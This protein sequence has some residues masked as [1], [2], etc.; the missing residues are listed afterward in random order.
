MVVRLDS[1]WANGGTG[2]ITLAGI[3]APNPP[4][5]TDG[6]RGDRYEEYEFTAW[7]RT[8]SG[9]LRKLSTIIDRDENNDITI[10]A[11]QP[12]V[13]VGNIGPGK[14]TLKISPDK[15]YETYSDRDDRG[16]LIEP[17]RKFTIEFTALGPMWDS[18]VSIEFP[19]DLDDLDPA[20]IKPA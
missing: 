12:Y 4:S 10:I 18:Q 20:Q 19:A 7:S 2:T 6:D 5:L 9:K 16:R 1:D 15:A 14:G 13:R 17:A 11:E 8:R 3:K